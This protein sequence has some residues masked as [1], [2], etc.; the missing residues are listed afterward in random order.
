MLNPVAEANRKSNVVAFGWILV[1]PEL[2]AALLEFPVLEIA[3]D[4]NV[5]ERLASLLA[6]PGSLSVFVKDRMNARLVADL[7]GLI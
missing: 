2:I 6:V 3:V 7:A 5:P 4:A 1:L